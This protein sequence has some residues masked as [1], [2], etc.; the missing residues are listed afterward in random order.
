ME[1]LLPRF[2]LCMTFPSQDII[3]LSILITLM[4]Y[5]TWDVLGLELVHQIYGVQMIHQLINGLKPQCIA[6]S[7]CE[8][9]FQ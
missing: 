4:N 2:T 8:S 1:T 3:G 7:I 9:Q 5:Q 6:Q